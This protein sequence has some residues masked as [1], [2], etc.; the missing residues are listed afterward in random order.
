M[1]TA[2]LASET[3]AMASFFERLLSKNLL[4]RHPQLYTLQILF[5]STSTGDLVSNETESKVMNTLFSFNYSIC[6][7][8]K[9]H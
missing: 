2:V 9:I 3:L 6:F 8:L 5:C 7:E 4:C 1:V